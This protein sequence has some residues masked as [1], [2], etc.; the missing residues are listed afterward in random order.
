MTSDE[1]RYDQLQ[2]LGCVPCRTLHIFSQIDVHHIVE[3][4]R[5]G[6]KFTLPLCPWHHRG[7]PP[8]D[9]SN[10]DAAAHYGPSMK[11]SKGAFVERFG[12]ERQLLEQT[13]ELI[14]VLRL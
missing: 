11:H 1:K 6:N 9:W 3:G 2:R 7:M 5:L 4:Y 14:K 8:D 12:T 10:S 13:D